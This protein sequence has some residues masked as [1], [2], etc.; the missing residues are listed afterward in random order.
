MQRHGSQAGQATP[1]MGL[2]IA[3]MRIAHHEI[4]RQDA[5]RLRLVQ[6]HYNRCGL[7]FSGLVEL[8]MATRPRVYFSRRAI[9]L[10]VSQR[11]PPSS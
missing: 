6:C 11:L 1:V 4:A 10:D 8:A 9:K 7:I 3:K 2:I 5:I